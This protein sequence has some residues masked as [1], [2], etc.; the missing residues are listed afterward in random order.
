MPD[1]PPDQ[2]RPCR[3]PGCKGH[4]GNP[5][6]TPH[7]MCAHTG[8]NGAITG[9]QARFL[10]DFRR[11]ILD[12]TYLHTQLPQPPARENARRSTSREYGHP[13]EW[14]SDK[15]ALIADIINETH[16]ALADALGD[17]PP[18]HPGTSEKTRVRAAWAYI[19]SHWAQLCAQYWA[20]DT[21]HEIHEHHN[22]IRAR[23]GHTKPRY[24]LPIP[25]PNPTCGLRTLTRT[26]DHHQDQ[27]TCGNCGYEVRNDPDGNN[28]QWLV[29]VCLDTLID[30]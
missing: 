2:T 20:G 6:Q 8:R 9:C 4:D 18:P 3:Y 14:A 23:L 30:Q 17:T 10:T 26:L 15:A 21:A 5:R 29:R 27:I 16:D 11:L 19:T 12:W 13:S 22:R 24:T 25:C 7:G 28:Y 1:L